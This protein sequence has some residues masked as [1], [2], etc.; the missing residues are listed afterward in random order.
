MGGLKQCDV[1]PCIEFI[2]FFVT[3]DPLR[4]SYVYLSFPELVERLFGDLAAH[5]GV[6]VHEL[7]VL[8]EVQPL[9]D[10]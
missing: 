7:V 2:S 3:P 1:S 5:L 10:L 9:G 4:T 8:V 6:D